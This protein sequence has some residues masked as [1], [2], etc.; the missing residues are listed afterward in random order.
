MRLCELI[1]NFVLLSDV[2]YAISWCE[3]AVLLR[4]H[5]N[6]FEYSGYLMECAQNIDV[7]LGGLIPGNW[8][9]LDHDGRA[10]EAELLV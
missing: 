7:G 3:G 5:Y 4:S 10:D 8:L 6:Y 9:L 2:I 1:F